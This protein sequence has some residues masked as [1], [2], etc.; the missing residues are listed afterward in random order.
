MN[1]EAVRTLAPALRPRV[2]PSLVALTCS[3]PCFF[4]VL[5][6][7]M[8]IGAVV[9]DVPVFSS[10][11]AERMSSWLE[12][13][14]PTPKAMALML[15]PSVLA[16]AAAAFVPAALSRT[17]LVDRLRLR[18][19]RADPLTLALCLLGIVGLQLAVT[20]AFEAIV[21][22][23]S[24]SLK[25]AEAMLV[26]PRGVYGALVLLVASAGS[27]F[28][29]EVF[30]RGY[31]Q[32]RLVEAWGGARGLILPSIFFALAHFD[33]QHSLAVFPLGVFMGIVAWRT[34]STW[35]A[36]ACHA[37]NN[38]TAI[39]LGRLGWPEEFGRAHV[40]ASVVLTLALLGCAALALRR[41]WRLGEL[42]ELRAP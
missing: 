28:A 22:E 27:G 11:G 7:L 9:D 19:P 3:T 41:L 25:L 12:E 6:V 20:R 35:T 23:P 14:A 29:E 10:E 2:W 33:S 32:S 8:A 13:I 38:F 42:A 18:A 17:R 15:A 16:F 24:E 31:V 21:D 1:D 34:G 39:G 4:V 36:I 30:F 26:E 5:G 40:L 37:L